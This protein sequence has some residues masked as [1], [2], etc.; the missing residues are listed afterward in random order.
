M[1]PVRVLLVGGGHAALPT[2]K[3]AN[4]LRDAGAEVTLIS[5]SRYLFYSGRTPEYIG[6]GYEIEDVRIDLQM[7]CERS[8][9]S[10][11]A[12]RVAGLDLAAR[13]V[14][15]AG[16][17]TFGADLMAIDV[18]GLNP[19]S[20]SPSQDGITTR[21]LSDLTK[22]RQI[23][24]DMVA[25]H[26]K[27]ET[28]SIIGGGAAG[29][30]IALN[31]TARVRGTGNHIAVF[32]PSDRLLPGFPSTLSRHVEHCLRERG[33]AVYLDTRIEHVEDGMLVAGARSFRSDHIVRATGSVG[34]AWLRESGL[35]TEATGYAVVHETLQ[36]PGHSWLFVAGDSASILSMPRLPKVGV[37]AVKQ[38]PT[39]RSNLIQAV[40]T[41]ASGG[42]LSSATFETFRPY[43]VAPLVLSTGESNGILASGRLWLRGKWCLDLK[44]RVDARWIRRYQQEAEP[45]P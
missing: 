17:S 22:L 44:H 43:P 30:E 39:L 40:R 15:T 14:T 41:L 13:R 24:D 19:P 21:P 29:T 12:D 16:G 26:R 32:E 23:V 36:T 11:V 42:G 38:G 3:H 8:G 1:A 34:Q 28:I 9:A 7:L 25:G 45:A 18:G 27:G 35:R 5:E 31:V 10:F 4:Q 2:I 20:P 37:H 33:A 6:G